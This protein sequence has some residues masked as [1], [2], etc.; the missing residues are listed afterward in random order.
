M[1]IKI[2]TTNKEQIDGVDLHQGQFYN[3]YLT[4]LNLIFY[5]LTIV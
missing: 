2:I 3:I 4:V 5:Y 1:L